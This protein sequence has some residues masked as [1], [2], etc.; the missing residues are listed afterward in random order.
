MVICY[1]VLHKIKEI[2]G[3]EK[4]G[5]TKILIE[6]GKKLSDDIAFWNVVIWIIRVLKDRSIEI[7]LQKYLWKRHYDCT[8]NQVFH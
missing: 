7:I 1:K 2:I 4:N 5:D 8:K 3:I 6:T